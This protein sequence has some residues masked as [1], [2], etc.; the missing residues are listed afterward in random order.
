MIRNANDCLCKLRREEEPKWAQRAKGKH[1]QEGGNNTKYFHLISNEK[2][3][4]YKIY[5]LSKRKGQ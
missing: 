2:H 5:Q 4:K 1:V 3:R